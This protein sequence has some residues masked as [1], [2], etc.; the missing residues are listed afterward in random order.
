MKLMFATLLL[1]SGCPHPPPPP[2]PIPA[3]MVDLAPAPPS[4]DPPACPSTET[5]TTDDV[6]QNKVTADGLA[7]ACVLCQGGG[8]CLDQ[9]GQY[10]CVVTNCSDPRCTLIDPNDASVS[11]KRTSKKPKLKVGKPHPVSK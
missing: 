6:C 10:Y 1:V 11:V 4:T 2:T 3:P 9:D 5:A 8:G 7:W